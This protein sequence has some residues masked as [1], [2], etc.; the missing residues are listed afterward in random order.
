MID[1][2]S[3]A[4]RV[5]IVFSFTYFSTRLL[6]KKA[7][8]QMTAYEMA[9]VIILTN[10]ATE[11]LSTSVTTKALFGTGFIVFLIILTSRLALID[12]LTPILEHKPTVLIKD[13]QLDMHALKNMDLTLNQMKGLLRQK[14]YD[15][16]SSVEYALLEPQGQL[17]VI[18]KSQKRP[19]QPSDLN[20]N[21]QYEGLT[22]PLIIDG[23][24]IERNLEHVNLTKEW[25]LNKLKKKGINNYKN[26]VNLAE[27][28]TS[29]KLSI[30]KN[31]G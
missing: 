4:T 1:F 11:P 17:S 24:I 30:S 16:V 21:T 7:I 14:G 23:V 9:G 5:L 15:K 22:I 13:G 8:A 2:L 29:G 25:L 12:K 18:P 10:V 28:D 6:S 26:E 31:T 27:L 19:I 3:Y 20:I